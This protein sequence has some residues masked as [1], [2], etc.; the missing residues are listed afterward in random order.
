[1][2]NSSSTGVHVHKGDSFTT[3]LKQLQGDRQSDM[4]HDN[5][6]TPLRY[7]NS[8][9]QKFDKIGKL[10]IFDTFLEV[11][12]APIIMSR[13]SHNVMGTPTMPKNSHKLPSPYCRLL[14]KVSM[15]IR[16]RR[17]L[18]P[19]AWTSTL[20]RHVSMTVQTIRHSLCSEFRFL[21]SNHH[22][23]HL[24]TLFNQMAPG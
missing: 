22:L 17:Y 12:R 10:V 4:L 7:N 11:I 13:S 8:P 16:W 3:K 21:Y 6:E 5:L 15:T 9:K 1:M 18:R 14:C 20:G 24:I 19:A 23:H 2:R